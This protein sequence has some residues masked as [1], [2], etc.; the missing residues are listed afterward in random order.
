ML[1]FSFCGPTL[2]STFPFA[3]TQAMTSCFGRPTY[4]VVVHV[5]H[6][7]ASRC[8]QILYYSLLLGQLGDRMP[9]LF[10]LGKNFVGHSYPVQSAG[11]VVELK[12][13]YR[14]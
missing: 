10:Y 12:G 4:F 8:P 1:Y 3:Q 13:Q 5:S 14:F 7:V 9:F 11:C 2:F 6:F